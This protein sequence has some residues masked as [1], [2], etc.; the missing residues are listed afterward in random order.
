MLN[1]KFRSS[2]LPVGADQHSLC[3][4]FDKTAPLEQVVNRFN[5]WIAASTILKENGQEKIALWIE[6]SHRSPTSNETRL[7]I[8][9]ELNRQL[10]EDDSSPLRAVLLIHLDNSS[11]LILVSHRKGIDRK[12]MS[13]L[14]LFCM[15][16]VNGNVDAISIQDH[17]TTIKHNLPAN[18]FENRAIWLSSIGAILFRLFELET[19]VVAVSIEPSSPNSTDVN[20]GFRLLKIPVSKCLTANSL[21]RQVIDSLDGTP[22]WYADEFAKKMDEGVA[23]TDVSIGVYFTRDNSG[24]S[25]SYQPYLSRPFPITIVFDQRAN[26]DSFLCCS[27]NLEHDSSSMIHCFLDGIKRCYPQILINEELA[28]HRINLLATEKKNQIIDTGKKSNLEKKSKTRLEQLFSAQA[29]RAPHA[30]ALTFEDKNITYLE[31]D[32]YSSLIAHHLIQQG[33]SQNS[34]VGICLERSID[35][36]A[37][38][39]AVLKAGAV[40]VPMDPC[41]PVDRLAYTCENSGIILAITELRN[42]PTS[43]SWTLFSPTAMGTADEGISIQAPTLPSEST[44]SAAYII[45]TSG[46]SGKPKGVV[47]SHSN[48]SN[49]LEATKEDFEL[50]DSDI[51][52]F[53]HSAAFDFSVWEIWGSLLTGARLVI[54]PYWVSRTPNDFRELLA[55]NKVTVLNQTPSAFLQLMRAESSTPVMDHLRLVIFGGEPLETKLLLPWFDRYSE[56][57]CRLVNMYGIT[58]TTVHV[59]AQTITRNEA[60]T[61]SRSVGSAIAGWY[62]YVLDQ[63]QNIL[64][65][66]IAGEIYVGGSGVAMQY[67]N[68]PELTAERFVPD[69]FRGGIMYKSGDKGRLLENGALE[70]LGRLDKQ[71]KL[72]GF[73]I[74]L[75]EIKKVLIDISGVE[76]ATV[77]VNQPVKDDPASTRIDSYIVVDGTHVQEVVRLA[78][79]LLP[80]YMMPST[81]TLIDSVPLTENGKIDV[82]KLPDPDTQ[83]CFIEK[84]DR[85]ET[86]IDRPNNGSDKTDSTRQQLTDNI[87]KIWSEVLGCQV[88]PS[89]NFF[90]LGGNSLFAIRIISLMEEQDL[91][92]LQL[93]ELYTHQSI[94]KLI[95]VMGA[96]EQHWPV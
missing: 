29:Q 96:D 85:I 88:H 20:H 62:V 16:S 34:S 71:I 21:K 2:R 15:G 31:L 5:R 37:T 59:T 56:D 52:T 60:L 12:M 27:Y 8:H 39:L 41:Y 23:K 10:S 7:L 25:T 11:D 48:V 87:V 61:T 64:P 83:N 82:K 42:F 40:Y 76:F 17:Q 69:P 1:D 65:F 30:I 36:V 4:H 78:S 94:A 54:V 38:M 70:H 22:L 73:R 28:L 18:C 55:K 44:D 58:E 84:S 51:W 19:T 93:R 13:A 68:Q 32:Q 35:L 33:V 86:N 89:D 49:L 6:S 90:T 80:D 9:K 72:R 3:T 47:V 46:S 57:R 91:P 45:Y 95:P 63:D 24:L 53:F 14:T 67:I 43:G 79:N 75:D 81:F 50:S 92:K 26:G 77:V 66:G 74:E